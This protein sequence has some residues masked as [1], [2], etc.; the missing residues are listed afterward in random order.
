MIVLY[1]HPSQ[2]VLKAQIALEEMGLDYKVVND[3]TLVEGTAAYDTFFAASPTGQVPAIYD[4]ETGAKV[5]ESAAILLYL[6]EKSGKFLPGPD[7]PAKRAEVQKWLVFEAA[8]F[9]PAML[10]IYHYTLQA[11]EN[12]PYAEDRAR[13]RARRAL[14]ALEDALGQDGGRDYLAG[15][16]SIAD[17]ILYPWLPILE[18]FADIDPADYPRLEAW[19]ARVGARAAVKKAEG[20]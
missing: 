1:A 3:R 18:D 19:T 16:Y 8:S 4:D 2:N 9:T 14:A 15:A 12:V 11:A 13:L 7:Q 5:F 10:D 17:M 20:A 6:A